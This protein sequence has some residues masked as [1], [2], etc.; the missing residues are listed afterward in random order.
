MFDIAQARLLAAQM[1]P[2]PVIW[3]MLVIVALATALLAGHGMASA[4][5]RNWVYMVGFAAT[6]AVASY[7]IVDL[8][9]PRL[10]LIRVNAFDQAL[11]DIRTSMK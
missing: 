7:V 11:I 6:T 5:G 10:G 9:Y 3:V 8:E 1:H 4:H 2:H